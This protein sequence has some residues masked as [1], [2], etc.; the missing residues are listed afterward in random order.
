MSYCEVEQAIMD[1][2]WGRKSWHVKR[3]LQLR[4]DDSFLSHLGLH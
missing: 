1:F 2:V 4:G 3:D